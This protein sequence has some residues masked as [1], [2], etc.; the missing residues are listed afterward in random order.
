[1]V[2]HFAFRSMI[3]FELIFVKGVGSVSRFLSFFFFFALNVQ[4]QHFL[5]KRLSLLHRIAYA[6]F[7]KGQLII[8]M[9]GLS[10]LFVLSH[11]SICLFSFC[12]ITVLITVALQ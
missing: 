10:G 4:F 2:L 12:H 3:Y 1:M 9:G 6:P 5:L 7:V 8:F 11:W